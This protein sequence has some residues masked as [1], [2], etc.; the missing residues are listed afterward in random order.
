MGDTSVVSS[1]GQIV[2]PAKLRKRYGLV[3][4]SV[5]VFQ[6]EDN[7]LVLSS[8]NYA[9]IY[10]LQGSLSGFPLEQTLAEERRLARKREEQQ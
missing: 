8:A 1:K 7:R 9:A 6:E 4:G 3:E 2:I 10:A 5:V